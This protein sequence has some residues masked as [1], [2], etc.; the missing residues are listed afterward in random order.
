MHLDR[1]GQP[2]AYVEARSGWSIDAS[3]ACLE[4]LVNP[5]ENRRVAASSVR[6]ER[7]PVEFMVEICGPCRDTRYA[8]LVNDVPVSDFCTPEFY[9]AT[10]AGAER[11]SWTRAVRAPF[12]TLPGGHISWFDSRVGEHWLRNHWSENPVDTNLGCVDRRIA[13]VRELMQACRSLSQTPT[14]LPY[15]RAS[16]HLTQTRELRLEAARFAVNEGSVELSSNEDGVEIFVQP[17]STEELEA[18]LASLQPEP[19]ADEPRVV[20]RPQSSAPPPLPTAG[21][22]ADVAARSQTL[23]PVSLAAAPPPTAL[24]PGSWV[25]CG[26]AVAAAAALALLNARGLSRERPLPSRASLHAS[27]APLTAPLVAA[28]VVPP[29]ASPPPVPAPVPVAVPVPNVVA[30]I[31]PPPSAE[32]KHHHHAAPAVLDSAV[33][34]PAPKLAAAPVHAAAS[35]ASLDDLIANRR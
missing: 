24:H 34:S 9:G 22:A 27:I 15:D 2:F 13:S 35:A 31:D 30:R 19:V 16:S 1:N 11:Y 8:Y 6:S 32:R 20:S 28:T 21:R 4:M 23:R 14:P 18:E 25:L 33:A 5:F 12:Q 17:G 26:A 7:T 29:R 10:A 3:R